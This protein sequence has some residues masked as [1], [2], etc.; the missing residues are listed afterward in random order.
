MRPLLFAT[1]M[2][3][4][5]NSTSAAPTHP[6]ATPAIGAG[7]PTT[8]ADGKTKVAIRVTREGFVPSE[9]KVLQGKPVVLEF[10]RETE[11]ECLNAVRMPWLT[12]TVPLPMNKP[13]AIPF[14][15]AKAGTLTYSCWMN[16]IFGKI[17]VTG[18]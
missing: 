1:L 14:D 12:E 17:T 9:V 5:C 4:A 2:L 3:A 10:T 13:V 7:E 18:G 15:A 6:S 8:T 11:S 16:M